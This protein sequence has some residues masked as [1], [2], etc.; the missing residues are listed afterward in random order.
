MAF[1]QA[2]IINSDLKMD[3]GKI[4]VQAAHGEII[5]SG[6]RGRENPC[7]SGRG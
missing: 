1:K 6:S 3:K 4:V 5:A 7:P 2:L